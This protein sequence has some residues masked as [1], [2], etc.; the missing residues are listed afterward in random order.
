MAHLWLMDKDEWAL[1]PLEGDVFAIEG[2]RVRRVSDLLSV[3]STKSS[4]GIRRVTDASRTLWAVVAPPEAR[5]TVNGMPTLGLAM[6]ADRDEIRVPGDRPLFFSTEVLAHIEPFPEADSHGL[7][8]R[9]KKPIAAGCPAVRCP[10]CGLWYH[11]SESDRLPC[12]TYA[13]HCAA[14]SHLTALDSGF[15]WTPEGL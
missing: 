7:C 3:A 8:P 9:C 15:R 4:I 14:C 6:L 2:G 11:E 1:L 10:I 5:V 12:W 13:T